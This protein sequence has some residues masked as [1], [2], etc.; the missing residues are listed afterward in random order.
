[1]SKEQD[2]LDLGDDSF[3]SFEDK[4]KTLGDVIRENTAVKIGLLIA[5]FAVVFGL[6]YGFIGST[7]VAAPS[8]VS[9]GSD[10]STPPGTQDA[11]PAYVEAVKEENQRRVERALKNPANSALPT[12]TETPKGELSIPDA[13][14][15]EEDPLQRW[16][17]L[18]EERLER[19]KNRE[20]S[21]NTLPTAVTEEAAA[22]TE[23]V[24]QMAE[25]MSKHMDVVLQ[26]RNTATGIKSLT[27]TSADWLEQQQEKAAQ[28]AQQEAQDQAQAEAE[29]QA[30]Q[31]ASKVLIPAGEII[32][33]QTLTEANSDNP[34]PVLAQI[35]V[36][37]LRGARLLGSFQTREE[38][39]TLEFKTLVVDGVSYGI[40]AVALDPDTTLPG[41]ATDVD[42][43]YLQRIAL[44]M[45]ASFIEGLSSAIS[46]SGRT[47]VTITGE[48][49]AEETNPTKT[50]EQVASGIEEAGAEAR[51]ILDDIAGD[52]ETLIVVATGTPFGLLFLDTVFD[53]NTITAEKLK[54]EQDKK[55]QIQQPLNGIYLTLPTAG[56]QGASGLPAT[57]G[58]SATGGGQN[59]V[60]P[61]L[62]TGTNQRP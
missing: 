28:K 44:P 47:T 60:L 37:P 7:D 21:Q 25:S 18:Q 35:A 48:T 41:L 3:D 30:Q 20:R 14:A 6:V 5:G 15:Q 23:A 8:I 52:T 32:F 1:M 27:V 33:A 26:N 38:V 2:D 45:A 17:R 24:K 39:L 59:S 49:V 61:N 46:D 19:E 56:N 42:H 13:P 54:E 29:I 12:P 22:R 55:D 58:S 9:Q 16:R 51:D 31:T 11:N 40:N 4:S 34:G 36:G 57:P 62:N 53:A 50:K 43:R 10:V